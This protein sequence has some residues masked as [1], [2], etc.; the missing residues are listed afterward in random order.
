MKITLSALFFL[1][2]ATLISAQTLE[3][4][5]D[6][7]KL[8]NEGNKL[9]KSG[10]YNGAIEKYDQALKGSNDYRIYYQKGVTYKKL[11]D[12][13]KAEEAFIKCTEAKPDFDI[14]YNGLGGTYFSLGQFE[15]AVKAFKKFEELSTK[16]KLKKKAGEYIARAYTKLGLSAKSKGSFDKAVDQL[17]NAVKYHPFDAAY[18]AL[19]E[20]YV[21]KGE[22]DNALT[23]AD[24]AIN[25]RKSISKG[26]GY[27]YKGLAFKG[28]DNKE[29]A[30]ENFKIAVK[31]SKYKSNSQYELKNLN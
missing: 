29:K 30:I 3:D 25:N 4:A 21:D 9:R 31:D 20:V 11:R 18:L 19:A 5:P 17:Q 27:Y 1:F 28:K 8:Y 24:N 13:K 16:P 2:L 14:A 12:Y 15:D 10:N 26:A 7:A 22:Y 6:A 23:A